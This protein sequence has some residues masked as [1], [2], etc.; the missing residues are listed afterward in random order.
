LAAL[1]C[2]A[3]SGIGVAM[4]LLVAKQR[5]EPQDKA[6]IRAQ[7]HI[8]GPGSADAKFVV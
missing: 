4:L 3:A 2:S 1:S 7:A 6:P 8:G 5:H